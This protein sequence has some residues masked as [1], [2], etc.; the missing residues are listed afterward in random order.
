MSSSKQ[1]NTMTSAQKKLIK[2][3]FSKNPIDVEALLQVLEATG[4][5]EHAIEVLLGCYEAPNIPLKGK[6]R[7]TIYTLNRFDAWTG[8]V[9]VTYEGPKEI[10]TWFKPDVDM[11]T[12][13]QS[14]YKEFE[15]R[16]DTKDSKFKTIQLD[17]LMEYP[18]EMKLEDWLEM[19]KIYEKWEAEQAQTPD[20]DQ[21]AV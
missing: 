10:S 16:Y 7:K 18:A 8:K 14:N 6:D 11:N 9:H 20:T 21:P 1:L 19:A 4:N 3:Y 2:G 5:S 12:I 13:N 17:E 15:A